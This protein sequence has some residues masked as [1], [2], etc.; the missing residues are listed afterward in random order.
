MTGNEKKREWEWKGMGRSLLGSFALYVLLQPVGAA[1]I[2]AE[3]VRE[4]DAAL[5]TGVFAVLAMG[6]SLLVFLHRVKRGRLA[7]CLGVACAFVAAIALAAAA[8][9]RWESV[10]GGVWILLIGAVT[11]AVA[12]ALIGGGRKRRRSVKKR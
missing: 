8:A 12:A 6:I 11:G 9:G 4:E 7:Q 3:A 10:V 1:L 2:S 5:L